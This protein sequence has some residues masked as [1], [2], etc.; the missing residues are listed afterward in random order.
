MSETIKDLE[1]RKKEQY[2]LLKRFPDEQHHCVGF[3]L[4]TATEAY[5]HFH[6]MLEELWDYGDMCNGHCLHTWDDGYRKL[7]RCRVC[8]GLVLQQRSEYHGPENDDYY[9]DYFPVDS[10][11]EAEQLNEHFG[12]FEIETKWDGKKVFVSKGHVTLNFR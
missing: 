7:C 4:P 10:V 12:G 9:T 6:G 5:D 3:D 1:H 8:G 2:E 11:Q